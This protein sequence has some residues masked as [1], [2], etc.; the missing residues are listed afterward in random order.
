LKAC[1][2]SPRS[3]ILGRERDDTF[4]R[5][6]SLIVALCNM[7]EPHPAAHIIGEIPCDSEENSTSGRR[8]PAAHCASG[9]AH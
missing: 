6:N 2:R 3:L 7:S 4:K 8:I 5:L 1:Q 9:G